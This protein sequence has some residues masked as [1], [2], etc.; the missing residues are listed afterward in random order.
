MQRFLHTHSFNSSL[1]HRSC[2]LS[3]SLCCTH[4]LSLQQ[5]SS[6]PLL[7]SPLLYFNIP[8]SLFEFLH[9]SVKFILS[10]VSCSFI[11]FL[12]RFDDFVVFKK[13]SGICKIKISLF[14]LLHF[15]DYRFTL[16]TRV[17]QCWLTGQHK[18]R[19]STQILGKN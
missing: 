5:D 6:S 14:L 4:P 11:H 16:P 18:T 9:Q 7:S 15:V 3:L 17:R 13:L 8:P 10:N 1:L 12:F 19:L 2:S